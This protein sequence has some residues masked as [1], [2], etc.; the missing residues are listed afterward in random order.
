MKLDARTAI[1]AIAITLADL[2]G[3][4]TVR[5]DAVAATNAAAD[6]ATAAEHTLEEL[7]RREQADAI[8]HATTE[9]EAR[10]AV[11]MVRL[12]YAR[13][14][15][16]YRRFRLA[17]LAAASAERAYDA[18]AAARRAPDVA[19]LLAAAATLADAAAALEAATAQLTTARLGAVTP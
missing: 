11:A 10:A 18:A 13:A 15:E 16:A 3:C 9:G 8:A 14:W 5:D 6:L 2:A 4:A 19:H 1:A 12:R 7:D 17:W